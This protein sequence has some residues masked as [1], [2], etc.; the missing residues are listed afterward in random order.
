MST[1]KTE[2]RDHRF[3]SAMSVI[4]ALLIVTGFANTYGP[5][6]VHG[7]PAVGAIV[8]LHAAVFAT[9]LVVFILQAVL[10]LRG[11]LQLHR[12]LGTVGI[13]LAGF[14]L[15]VGALTA[16]TVTR[17]GHRG[18]PG[19]EFPEPSAFLLLNLASVSVFVGLALAGW[20]FRNNPQAHKR[21]MLMAT[22]GG[23][24]PPG[25]A[26]LPVIGGQMPHIAIVALVLVLAGPIYDLVT[27]RRLHP[28]Y[29]V[30][31]G[32]SLV[33]VPPVIAFFST[34]WLWQSVAGVL[35]G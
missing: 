3:F 7:T 16:V 27:R 30:G 33:P 5:K 17:D 26:R 19:A 2:P 6:L 18:I 10:V 24:A 8:H 12:K 20:V 35:L 14:M 9:W 1:F 29:V 32:A 21:L 4:A 25:I 34:T 13:A 22:V 23:L 28:A 15:F 11:R 31:V